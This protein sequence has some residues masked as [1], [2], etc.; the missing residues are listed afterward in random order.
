MLE[1]AGGIAFGVD[2]GNFLQLQ[3][4][5]QRERIAGAAAE[6]EDVFG[7]C[8]VAR[9]FFD[10]RLGCQ[11]C[12]HQ[13][14]NFHQPMHELGFIGIGQFAAR[15][16][17]GHRDRSQHHQLAG[18]RLGRGDADFRAGQRRHHGLA[19][20]RDG[21]TRH[22]DDGKRVHALR[23]GVAQRCQRI[24]GLAGL[25]DEDRE[26]ALAQGGDIEFYG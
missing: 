18:E 13:A 16:A 8:D 12:G 7:F 25:R 20:A 24:G 19:F 2:V 17:R 14:R 4:A 3:R 23:F 5:F 10:V 26:I 1:F 6:I 22:I 11:R 15:L 21:R 9:Q